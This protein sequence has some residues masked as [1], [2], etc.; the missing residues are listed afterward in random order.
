MVGT[1]LRNGPEQRATQ[2]IATKLRPD[3]K[4]LQP[5]PASANKTGKGKEI[6]GITRGLTAAAPKERAGNFLR[7]KQRIVQ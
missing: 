7:P 2:A 6:D 4:V 5:K 1:D 3:I